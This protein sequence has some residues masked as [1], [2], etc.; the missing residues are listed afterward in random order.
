MLHPPLRA[1]HLLRLFNQQ[2][3]LVV[4][5]EQLLRHRRSRTRTVGRPFHISQLRRPHGHRPT[6]AVT[7]FR[8]LLLVLPPPPHHL[9][10]HH[11]NRSQQALEEAASGLLNHHRPLEQL[12]SKNSLLF[13]QSHPHLRST[14]GAH[15][16]LVH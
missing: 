4:L 5:R 9:Q 16:P 1:V 7:R 8:H 3:V 15:L 14:E 2:I 12:Y 6:L 10:F 11:S 13:P